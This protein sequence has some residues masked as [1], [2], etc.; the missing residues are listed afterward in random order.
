MSNLN[1]TGKIVVE[2]D[3][4]DV[5]I[6]DIANKNIMDLIRD[7]QPSV[8]NELSIAEKHENELRRRAYWKYQE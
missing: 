1:V 8:S 3:G 6:T 4:I 2:V 5:D 7:W